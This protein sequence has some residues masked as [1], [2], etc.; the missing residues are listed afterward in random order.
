MN[1]SDKL[2]VLW[3]T[4]ARTATRSVGYIMWHHHFQSDGDGRVP[5][6]DRQIPRGKEEYYYIVNVRNPYSRLVSLYYLLNLH[7]SKDFETT[8]ADWFHKQTQSYITIKNNSFCISDCIQKKPDKLIKVENLIEDIQSLF[9]LNL[10]D[11]NLQEIIENKIKK[12]SFLGEFDFPKQ[13]W[14]NFY[15]EELADQ[16]YSMCEKDFINFNYDKNSWK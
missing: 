7:H 1:W 15:N 8:F 2:K 13:N 10:E 6:H 4:P 11:E 5:N 14:K 16:V 9:F 12:N 3:Y